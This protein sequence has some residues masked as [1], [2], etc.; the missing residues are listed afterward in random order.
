MSCWKRWVS[1]PPQD[2]ANRH[3]YQLSGG[4]RQRVA[5]ARALAVQPEIILADEPISMLDVSIRM[6][7]LNLMGR[8][9]DEQGIGFLYITHDLASAR[10]IADRTIVM[11][12]GHMVEGAD[13]IELMDQPAHPYTKLLISAV[14]DPQSALSTTRGRG[15][16]RDPLVDRPA[17][18]LPVRDPLP[19]CD[20]R[21]PHRDARPRVCQRRSLGA[22]PSLRAGEGQDGPKTPATAPNST[23]GRLGLTAMRP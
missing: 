12:A 3:P 5:I 1:R 4:Q 15:A 7:V 22:L 16:R 20:G 2:I 19:L 21:L 8:L 17:A 23:P 6:G 11:Y 14:P 10:Y 18:R 13:S 9:K